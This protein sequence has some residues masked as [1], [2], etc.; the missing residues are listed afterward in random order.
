MTPQALLDH[1][2]SGAFWPPSHDVA[3]DGDLAAAG[4][5]A[6]AVRALREQRGDRVAGFKLGWTNRANWG[7]MGVAGPMW[8]TLH[9]STVI[10]CVGQADVAVSPA[11]L[12]RLEAEV[13][14][15]FHRAP[16]AVATFATLFDCI[17]W[18]APGF[19]IVQSHLPD[20][21]YT[22]AQTIADCAVHARLVVGRKTPVRAVAPDGD[23]LAALLANARVRLFESGVLRAEGVGASVLDGPLHAL[24]QFVNASQGRPE[25]SPKAGDL[26]T[27]GAWTPAQP[28]VPGQA[29][30]AEFDAPIGSLQIDLR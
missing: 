5:L 12:P 23:A 6:L 4:R 7:A 22:P 27:T 19:E 10:A 8:G 21:R 3:R 20:W 29:W 16:P 2:D 26:V 14:V 11:N 15:G 13:V 1:L 18:I 30:R 9:E 17:E 24:R 28:L 25:S